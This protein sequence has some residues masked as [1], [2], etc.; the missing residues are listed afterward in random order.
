MLVAAAVAIVRAEGF[1]GL[2]VRRLAAQLGCG[3]T[4]VYWHVQNKD[5]LLDLVI[6][7]LIGEIQVP[8]T[9]SAT[10]RVRGFGRSALA[11]LIVH[12]GLAEHILHR[13]GS[14][15]NGVAFAEQMLALLA[16][17]GVRDDRLWD[18]YHTILVYLNGFAIAM[19]ATSSTPAPRTSQQVDAYLDSLEPAAIPTIRRALATPPLTS[20]ARFGYGLDALLAGFISP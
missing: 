2:S 8:M 14:G 20:K 13:G 10:E 3:A 1:A 4:S 19:T 12:P 9:G 16:A 6:D 7:E 15:P 17:G 11:V 5:Q 18:T